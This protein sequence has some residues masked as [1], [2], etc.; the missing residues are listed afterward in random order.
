MFRRKVRAKLSPRM[1]VVAWVVGTAS[2]MGLCVLVV[3][4]A[5]RHSALVAWRASLGEVGRTQWPDWRPE[6]PPL[7]P[8]P[9]RRPALARDLRGPYAFAALNPEQLRFIPCYCGCGRHGHQSVLACF[10]RGFTPAGAPVWTDH[11]YTCQTCVD[12]VRE[13]LLMSRRGMPVRE[14]R[15][16]IDQYHAGWFWRPTDTPIPR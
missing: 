12:I 2:T 10:V 16:A 1:R 5:Q 8:P 11:A 4:T 15:Q 6:W 13:V 7:P 14:I 3:H 9:P